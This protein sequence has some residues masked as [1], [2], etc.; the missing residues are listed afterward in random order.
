MFEGDTEFAIE[1]A[2]QF[3]SQCRAMLD[4]IYEALD[5]GDATAMKQAAHTLKGSIGYF[6]PGEGQMLLETIERIGPS[7]LALV[8]ALLC[9]LEVRVEGLQRFLPR[10]LGWFPTLRVANF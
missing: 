2:T 5:A 6:D 3:S 1:L 10:E 8:P 4:A 7:D 9:E